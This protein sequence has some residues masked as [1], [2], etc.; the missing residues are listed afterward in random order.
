[1]NKLETLEDIKWVDTHCHLQ[2]MGDEINEQDISNLEYFI[3]PGVDIPSSLKAKQF[4]LAYPEKSYWSAGLHPHEADLLDNVKSDLQALMIE[5]DLIGET[6]L[7]YYRNLSSKENQI[8]SFEYHIDVSKEL[9]K[10]L[11][12][13]CR[14][15]FSD[16]YE[17][18]I[19]KDTTNPIILHSWTGGNKWTK[20]FID[21][22]VYFSISGIVTY[23]TAHDLQSAVKKIPKD[24][25][26]LETDVPYLAPEPFKGKRN[27]PTYIK[28]TGAK[29]A[30]LIGIT[31]NDLSKITISNTNRV[32]NREV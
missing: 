2:L 8:R 26:L 17:T 7:D 1:V 32:M 30:E 24:K 20:K 21:L 11:I 5:A 28:H 18:L 22:D 12:I 10:P 13:H 19:N 14:D 9:N 3:I 31:P 27:N 23:D 25:I 16:V 29:L 15:S 6:G 4:S